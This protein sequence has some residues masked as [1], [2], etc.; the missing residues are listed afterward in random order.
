[1]KLRFWLEG[2]FGLIALL[3]VLLPF[4]MFTVLL[5]NLTSGA[6]FPEYL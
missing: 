6:F 2:D 4:C 5:L 1:M 3:S